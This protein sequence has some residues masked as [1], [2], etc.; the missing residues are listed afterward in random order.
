MWWTYD[1]C[2]GPR[3]DAYRMRLKADARPIPYNQ[4]LPAMGRV[5]SMHVLSHTIRRSF[6]WDETHARPISYNQFLLSMG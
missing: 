2:K 1:T 6:L 5:S 3:L 4:C